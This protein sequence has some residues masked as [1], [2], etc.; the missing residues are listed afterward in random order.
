M[1]VEAYQ[2]GETKI[3]KEA[4][5]EIDG[6]HQLARLVEV[7]AKS[8]VSSQLRI[9]PVFVDGSPYSSGAETRLNDR[10]AVIGLVWGRG[11]DSDKVGSK[12]SISPLFITASKEQ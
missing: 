10:Y 3:P 5:E 8:G 2:S 11:G 7:L 9:L 4:G 6:P 12:E 1:A